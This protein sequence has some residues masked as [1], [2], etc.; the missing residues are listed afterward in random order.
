MSAEA[1]VAERLA[2]LA[3]P[4]VVKEVR[5]GLRAKVFAICF[6]LLLLACV[7]AA[8]VAAADASSAARPTGPDYLGL[9]FGAQTVV[10]LFVIPFTAFR[11]MAKE[12]EE[13]TWVLLALTGM[14]A[15][16]IVRGKVGSALAQAL[17]FASCCAPF[18]LFS[19]Y[20]NGVDVVT[21]GVGLWLTFC[22]C[23]FLVCGAVALGT[24]GHARVVRTGV[25]LLAVLLLFGCT[26]I[27]FGFGVGLAK[28][29]GQW[30]NEDG[31]LVVVGAL[32]F[33]LLS[34]AWVLVEAA[35]SNLALATENATGGVRKALVVQHLL[36]LGLAFAAAFHEKRVEGQL[37]AALSV[38]SSLMLV[39]TGFFL[40]SEDDGY[41]RK[42]VGRPRWTTPG[43]KRGWTLLLK[44]LALDTAG[45][46]IFLVVFADTERWLTPLLAAP[47]YVAFYLSLAAAL[48]RTPLLERFG[49]KGGTR[50]AFAGSVALAAVM[51]PVLSVVAGGR[52]NDTFFNHLNPFFG[53]V[54][55]LE[56]SWS[57]DAWGGLTALGLFC[58]LSMAF[59][60]G[61]LT[62]KDRERRA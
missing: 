26:A 13:E 47:A 36:G 38:V 8:L 41:T 6:G 1:L 14:P 56:R 20:L 35:A 46:F 18:V 32:S 59:A 62:A 11:S 55:F 2:E 43:A 42:R 24:E 17:L 51:L 49:A 7:A 19:Y 39:A 50:A 60:W 30:V 9:F 33:A 4:L 37:A 22:A 16:R 58:A 57:G 21:L 31:F 25:Q 53:M 10:C 29:G 40:V 5:Q 44:L 52:A 27:A 12:R 48:G 28:E 45:W 34:G 15:R 54:N 61:Q 23:V 3:G